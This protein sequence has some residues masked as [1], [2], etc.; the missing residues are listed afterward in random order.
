MSRRTATVLAVL[1]AA[2]GTGLASP[3]FA[4]AGSLSV[5]RSG[6]WREWWREDR[7]PSRWAAADT[8][9]AGA[10]D[11]ERLANGLEWATLR[12]TCP[13][14]AWRA[15]IIVVRVDPRVLALSLEMDMTR[16]QH[17]AWSIDRAPHDALLA[18]NAGQFVGSMP[19]GWVL[20]DGREVL[21]PGA[22][23]LVSTVSIDVTGRVQ[24]T[25]GGG[26]PPAGGAVTGFQSYPTLLE[27]DGTVPARLLAP[28]RGV[29]LRHRDARLALGETRDGRLIFALTRF[30]AM[31]D[32]F[33]GTPL[34][35]T[36]PEM[37]AILGA[38]GARDAVMLDGG[39]S[40]QL[41]LRSPSLA[42]PLRWPGW[43]RVPLALIGRAR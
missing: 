36:T 7:A 18:I 29:D 31:G 41:Q 21:P 20:I 6:A 9:V 27:R 14:P 2:G 23:P 16:E 26:R 42:A 22:G 25:H 40:A 19:W 35:P 32:F 17:P 24:W 37:A 15:K 8:L 43:R 30:D 13:A 38:L 34:G 12:I 10:L 1:L 3:A 33:S 11:W 28:D 39:I 4:R 5:W